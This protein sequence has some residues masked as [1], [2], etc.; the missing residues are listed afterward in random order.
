MKTPSDELDD[1]D[2]LPNSFF[3]TREVEDVVDEIVNGKRLAYAKMSDG[4]IVPLFRA[5]NQTESV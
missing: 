4:V 1:I 2:L 5:M 3:E